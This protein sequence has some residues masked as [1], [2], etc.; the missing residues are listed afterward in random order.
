M[1]LELLDEAAAGLGGLLGVDADDLKVV[2]GPALVEASPRAG[3]S[4]RH[5]PHHEAQ[6]FTSTH[7]PP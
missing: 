6:T 3:A 4:S 2:A 1:S 7:L 5:G